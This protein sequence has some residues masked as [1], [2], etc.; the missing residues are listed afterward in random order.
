MNNF[1]NSNDENLYKE[2]KELSK[3]RFSELLE[4]LNTKDTCVFLGSGPSVPLGYPSIKTIIDNLNAITELD[5]EDE[6]FPEKIQRCRDNMEPDQYFDTIIS[7]FSGKE[8]YG[9][10]HVELMSSNF[11]SYLTT[12]YDKCLE[13][14]AELLNLGCTV[15]IFPELTYEFI[16]GGNI[17][18]LH[19]RIDPDND[20]LEYSK[21]IV[22]SSDDYK[23]AYRLGTDLI[24]FLTSVFK[25]KSVIFLGFGFNEEEHV[26]DPL[27]NA[28]VFRKIQQ[29]LMESY[30]YA[31]K[32]NKRY[33][34]LSYP[35]QK[36]EGTD[37]PVLDSE[38]LINLEDRLNHFGIET[39]R[40]VADGNNHNRLL[41]H[42][43]R[44]K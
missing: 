12:N 3:K 40:Y 17:Y 15:E 30:G 9:Q 2:Y 27:E 16:N 29:N 14:A 31:P 34:F 23:K 13:K 19:G 36:L 20:E 8:D 42:I 32:N 21:S 28:G 24:E 25:N 33:A 44:I 26:F 41:N 18:H 4:S 1:K 11:T 22:L 35:T 6:G 43:K 7:L 38:K 37:V 39:I 5:L 10:I